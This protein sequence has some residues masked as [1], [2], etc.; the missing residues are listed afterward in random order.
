MDQ[1]TRALNP[2]VCGICTD[3]HFIMNDCVVNDFVVLFCEYNMFVYM[4]L[5]ACGQY[6]G[7]CILVPLYCKVSASKQRAYVE[8]LDSMTQYR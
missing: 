7:H 2:R 4:F 6:C 3:C 8:G 1:I 5:C